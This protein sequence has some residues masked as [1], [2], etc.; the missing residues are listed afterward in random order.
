MNLYILLK[1][2]VSLLFF[3]EIEYK[4]TSEQVIAKR[5]RGVKVINESEAA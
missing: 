5:L 2:F 1:R 4:L 3:N